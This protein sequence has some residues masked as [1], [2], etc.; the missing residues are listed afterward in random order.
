MKPRHKRALLILGALGALAIAAVLIL[1]ALNSNIALYVTPSEVAAG[2]APQGQAF[3]IGGLVKAGSLRRDE[4]VVHFVIT[5]LVKEIP[6]SYKGILPDLFKEGKGAVVQGKLDADGQFVATEVL[7][8]HDENYMPP[9]AKHALEQA[10]KNG[11]K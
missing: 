5:D 2:K 4:L 7:A 9:E 11:A 10:Q 1:N 8:K 3:R 6:V